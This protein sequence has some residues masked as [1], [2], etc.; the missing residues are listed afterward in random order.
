[1]KKSMMI[2]AV[3]VLAI[4]SV[5]AHASTVF[6]QAVATGQ[7]ASPSSTSFAF[8]AGAGTGS[9]SFDLIGYN[10]LDGYNSGSSGNC[11]VCDDKFSISLNNS[12][13]FSAYFKLGGTGVTSIVQ[14]LDGAIY[15]V[16]D[17]VY[18]AGGTINFSVPLSLAAGM[19][20]LTF[21][22]SGESQGIDDEAFGISNLSVNGNAAAASPGAVPE[23]AT[24]AMM[25]IGFG[26]IGGAMRRRKATASRVNYSFA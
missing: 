12:L 19:N 22:Y 17:T 16:P 24:W 25:L 20:T 13:L 3:A 21:T 4:G 2:A 9:A 23:P 11:N 26:A 7:L 1:M 10:T 14:S 6:T 15:S 5:Q 18:G 8:N